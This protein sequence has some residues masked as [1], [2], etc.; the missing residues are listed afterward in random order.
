EGMV[1]G[2]PA[3]VMRVSFTGELG[4]E[5]NVPA[6]YGRS[7]WEAV[8]AEGRKVDAVAYGTEAMHVMRAEKGYIIVGQETDG[9]VT[10][11]DLGLN[12]TIGKAKKDFVGKRSLIR[13]D[14]IVEGRKQLVGLLT[15]NPATVLEEGA[16]ITA[17]ATPATGT[18]ALGHV[19]S[20]YESPALGRSIALALVAD[21]R[22]RMGE[23]LFVPMPGGAIA[24]KIV[25]PVFVD[26]KGDRINE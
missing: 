18:R 5:I 22:K 15:E 23:T 21:G 11:D 1:C 12:W 25:A 17:G 14:M 26:P 9:T 4:Y 6:D 13:P 8:W 2:V 10:P 3:R 24:V 16:Q 20:S 7:V 19:T